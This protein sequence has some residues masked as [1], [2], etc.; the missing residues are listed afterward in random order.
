MSVENV[1]W[2][3][4]T[5]VTLSQEN[6]EV[7][8]Q[9]HLYTAKTN[10]GRDNGK[11]YFELENL[12]DTTS[13]LV[14]IVNSSASLTTRDYTSANIKMY[15]S[16]N[17]NKYPESITYG[18][19]FVKGDIIG[20]FLDIDNGMMEFY[21]NGV[22][23]GVSH[24]DISTMGTIFPSI[25][26]GSTGASATARAN[27]GDVNFKY[28]PKNLPSDTLAYNGRALLKKN[29]ILKNPTT[30]QHY[31][32]AE[33]TLVPL[34]DTSLKNMILHGIEAGKE[35]R[36]DED[37]NKIRKIT[38][39]EDST[40]SVV[41]EDVEPFSVYD[42]ISENP[43][44][45]ICT[46]FTDDIVVSTTTEP[47]DLYDEFG[48]EVDVLFYTDEETVTEAGLILEA[49]WS[50]VDELEGDFEIVTWT[51]ET[52]STRT[53]E[54]NAIPKPQFIA[55]STVSDVRGSLNGV[56]T[57]TTS[58]N[59]RFLLTNNNS[60]WYKWNGSEFETVTYAKIDDILT[61]GNTYEELTNA[62]YSKWT[63]S[64]INIGVFLKDDDANTSK[65][66]ELGIVT[67]SPINTSQVSDLNFYIL[68]TTAKIEL[69]LKGLWLSGQLS[70][71]DLTRVQY[72]VF[73]NEQPYFPLSGQFTNLSNPPLNIDITFK[74][75]EVKI[76]DWNTLRVEFKDSFG[77][78]DYWQNTFVGNY[79]SLMFADTD[80]NYYSDDVGK[81]L[82]YLDFGVFFG[83]QYTLEH[84][85]VIKN[86]YGYEVENL[87]IEAN[88]GHLPEG[89][90]VQ[91][92]ET[93]EPFVPQPSLLLPNELKNDEQVSF[94]IRM[95]S[96]IDSVPNGENKFNIFVKAERK[97]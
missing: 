20:V 2:S 97:V 83:G 6:L 67:N 87:M 22:S 54:I 90:E 48:D 9:S 31:S 75:E 57:S 17:G 23:Q 85:V 92:S 11:Y 79:S 53:L 37:F 62:D 43:Q 64:K 88:T 19:P 40:Q 33:K 49:N 5:G 41:D 58:P 4:N 13:L 51:D 36:L 56:I 84:E 59:V 39:N 25:K 42:Y 1:F 66:N 93:V 21:K 69:D 38:N 30:N 68:N 86:Q 14:G 55:K 96:D 46:E 32:L 95:I 80:G 52:D 7:T 44:I 77:T 24:N 18:D 71:L 15:F 89:V 16:F 28:I 94:Y 47:Y 60:A 34:P 70:D 76:N 8:V 91:F 45:V 27:F 12:S 10:I 73:L 81:V 65:I 82:Q 72:R 3:A 50:P 26:S 35:I 29:M 74:S 61:L 78:V 63:H